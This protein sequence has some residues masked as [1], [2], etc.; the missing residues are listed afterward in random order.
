[1]EIKQ[2]FSM[3]CF[4]NPRAFSTFFSVW[5]TIVNIEKNI[6]FVNYIRLKKRKRTFLAELH[7]GRRAEWSAITIETGVSCIWYFMVIMACDMVCGRG[8]PAYLLKI[9]HGG[10]KMATIKIHGFN[11]FLPFVPDLSIFS[12]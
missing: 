3:S 4:E 7:S 9:Q 6:M 2:G 12:F 1:M 10:S 11:I 8:R 5:L